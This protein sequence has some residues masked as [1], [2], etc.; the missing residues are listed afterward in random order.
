MD[1]QHAK[2]ELI[3]FSENQRISFINLLIVATS[4]ND[5]VLRNEY[6]IQFYVIC[7][8]SVDKCNAYFQ[9]YGPSRL[10]GDLYKLTYSQRDFIIEALFDIMHST[11]NE[12]TDEDADLLSYLLENIGITQFHLFSYSER[13][14]KPIKQSTTTPKD[15]NIITA[16]N[17][18]ENV[19]FYF[20]ED[21]KQSVTYMQQLYEFIRI[22][23][24][25]V[26]LEMPPLYCQV[27]GLA[28]ARMALVFKNGDNDFNSVAAENAF[29]CL[30]KSYLE[31]QNTFTLPAIFTLL[32]MSSELLAYKFSYALDS[33]LN[34][35]NDLQIDNKYFFKLYYNPYD[36]CKNYVTY[37]FYDTDN[38]KFNIPEDL[39]Y[40]LP[41]NDDIIKFYVHI[42]DIIDQDE[43]EYLFAGKLIFN[44]VYN[45]IKETL[46]KF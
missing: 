44:C 22:K 38:L 32:N 2:K 1:I 14:G 45:E 42:A 9:K 26:L 35:A 12:F 17:I 13:N 21:Y 16:I 39:P 23:G 7:K 33:S 46:M 29:Y 18:A 30:A 27:V 20:L 28:F 31:A 8:V 24:C 3:E 41:K 4:Q 34:I 6:L 43:L 36:L 10:N 25:K 5:N 37:I 40:L 15:E 19:N 11:K